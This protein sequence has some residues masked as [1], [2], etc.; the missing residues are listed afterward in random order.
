MT[1]ETLEAFIQQLIA[2]HRS[3]RVTVA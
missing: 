2:T 3:N 1:E